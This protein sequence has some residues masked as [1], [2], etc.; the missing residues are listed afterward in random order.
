MR[1][2]TTLGTTVPRDLPNLFA[3]ATMRAVLADPRDDGFSLRA[4]AAL[5]RDAPIASPGPG[6]QRMG[7][8]SGIFSALPA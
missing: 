8:V 2:K 3:Y 6:C 7:S 4:G 1:G 5:W